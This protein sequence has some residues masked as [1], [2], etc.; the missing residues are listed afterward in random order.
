M[1]ASLGTCIPALTSSFCPI[2]RDAGLLSDFL[3]ALRPAWK[4]KG[5]Q[6]VADIQ[7]EFSLPLQFNISI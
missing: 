7:V 6:V 4:Q 2:L 3:G 1:E 5:V